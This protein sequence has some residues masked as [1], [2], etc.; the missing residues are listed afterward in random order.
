MLSANR[1]FLCRE[2]CV[3]HCLGFQNRGC[4]IAFLKW[5]SGFSLFTWKENNLIKITMTIV[6]FIQMLHKHLNSYDKLVRYYLKTNYFHTSIINKMKFFSKHMLW[7]VIWTWEYFIQI[8]LQE[9]SASL[10]Y[11]YCHLIIGLNVFV[12]WFFVCFSL[13]AVCWTKALY[14]SLSWILHFF[15]Y[16]LSFNITLLNV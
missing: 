13:G 11:N 10:E 5:Q 2:E 6:S 1:I 9:N 15:L 8:K 14:W 3:F 12:W 16:G 4:V 7:V